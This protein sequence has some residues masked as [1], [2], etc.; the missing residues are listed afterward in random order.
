MKKLL[1][2]TSLSAALFASFN[3]SAGSDVTLKVIGSIVPGACVPTLPNGG[4][5]DYGTLRNEAIAP[6]GVTN[7]LVQ[8]GQKSMTLTVTCDNEIAVAVTSSDNRSSS[9]VGLN[10]TNSY[11]EDGYDNGATD[12]HATSNG[13]GLGTTTN[14]V[15]IGA[16]SIA[17]DTTAATADSTAVDVI[18]TDDVNATTVTWAAS[19]GA[20]CSLTSGC[21]AAARALT[22]AEKGS[23]TPKAFKVLTAPMVISAAVQDNSVLGTDD[24]ITLDGNATISLVYL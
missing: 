2:A 8:L 7:K 19:N 20:F 13:F 12:V 9:N 14:S 4:T 5:I 21:G 24:T 16:Y 17:F 3:A 18:T 11:I 15:N 22:V 23:L 6:T 10:S 1:I